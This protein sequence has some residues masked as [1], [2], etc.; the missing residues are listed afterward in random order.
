MLLIDCDLFH[1]VCFF[2]YFFKT[3]VQKCSPELYESHKKTYVIEFFVKTYRLQVI[4]KRLRQ[5]F[6]PVKFG[7]IF[8]NSFLLEASKQEVFNLGH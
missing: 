6:F 4:K 8:Q 2:G 7:K 1:L 3:A 5:R